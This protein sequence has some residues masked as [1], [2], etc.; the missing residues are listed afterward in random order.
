VVLEPA[1]HKEVAGD[2]PDRIEHGLAGYAPARKQ[3]GQ[4]VSFSLVL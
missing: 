4:L 2:G 1:V 3:L